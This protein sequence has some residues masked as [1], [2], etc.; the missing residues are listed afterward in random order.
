MRACAMLGRLDQNM[1]DAVKVRQELDLRIGTDIFCIHTHVHLYLSLYLHSCTCTC[2][3]VHVC[4]CTCTC[5]HTSIY[6]SVV[7]PMCV[8]HALAAFLHVQCG[9]IQLC[10]VSPSIVYYTCIHAPLFL[11]MCIYYL[12][13]LSLPPPPPPSSLL[14]M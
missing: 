1:S 13:F 10:S 5:V 7:V 4:E 8:H 2:T 9:S 6:L 12:S 3:H 14:L 11:Y